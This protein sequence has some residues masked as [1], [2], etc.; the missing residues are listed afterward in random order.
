MSSGEKILG[1]LIV[2]AGVGF[3]YLCGEMVLRIIQDARG[4]PPDPVADDVDAEKPTG[5]VRHKFWW[6][7]FPGNH[8][9]VWFE[10]NPEEDLEENFER[11][12]DWVMEAWGHVGEPPE[13]WWEHIYEKMETILQRA[14]EMRQEIE[15]EEFRKSLES[16]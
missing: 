1:A 7:V 14:V 16:L 8:P 5:D 12:E 4:R 13:E 15:L 3:L 6:K 10:I 9:G 2:V 11:F